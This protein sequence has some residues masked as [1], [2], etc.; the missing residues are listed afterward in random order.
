MNKV[1]KVKSILTEEIVVRGSK[2]IDKLDGF[3]GSQFSGLHIFIEGDNLVMANWGKQ[4]ILTE[5][6][7]QEVDEYKI[8]ILTQEDGEYQHITF[9]LK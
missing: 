6:V 1:D 5:E 4:V 7:V 9:N 2:H 3:E 8:V